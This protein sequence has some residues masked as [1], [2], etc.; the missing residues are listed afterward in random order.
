[1]D[2]C[3]TLALFHNGKLDQTETIN[4]LAL[5]LQ[6]S[7]ELDLRYGLKSLDDGILPLSRDIKIILRKL[8]IVQQKLVRLDEKTAKIQKKL[9]KF[10]DTPV[11]RQAMSR[12]LNRDASQQETLAIL[13]GASKNP[14]VKSFV[15]NAYKAGNL[16]ENTTF[17]FKKL[18]VL[19]IVKA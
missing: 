12:F 6:E 11:T 9:Q 19:P 18:R 15:S 5:T 7:D 8:G 1:M 13:I 3:M 14:T 17:L 4:L 16:D 10:R 2:T